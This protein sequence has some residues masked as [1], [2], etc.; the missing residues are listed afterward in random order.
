MRNG[1]KKHR[2]LSFS[3]IPFTTEDMAY[4][5]LLAVCLATFNLPTTCGQPARVDIPVVPSDPDFCPIAGDTRTAIDELSA[6]AFQSLEEQTCGGTRGWRRIA[7]INMTDSSHDCPPGFEL[8][9]YSKRTCGS[10]AQGGGCG[11]TTFG[12]HGVQYS[13]VCGRIIGYKYYQTAAFFSYYGRSQTTIH[14]Y[15]VDGISLTTHGPAGQREHIWTFA[16]SLSDF[17]D[18]TR[19]NSIPF[20]P[21]AAVH[22]VATPPFVGDDYF[23]ES[24]TDDPVMGDTAA[25]FYPD[26]P[27]WD[28]MDCG[29]P[30]GSAC[31]AFNNPPWFTKTLPNPTTD[32]IE[33]RLCSNSRI[34]S[35]TPIELI[36]LYIK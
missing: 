10:S 20:C 34:H 15:Y 8:T 13:Q 3:R 2:L 31:C 1:Y 30:S 28:G 18:G 33:L 23:C 9:S 16:A 29:G 12:V 17:D 25:V 6:A 14:G 19:S 4:L 35:Q 27:L 26:D 11:A 36:E 7:F 22:P 24:G 21:C 32:V 5:L